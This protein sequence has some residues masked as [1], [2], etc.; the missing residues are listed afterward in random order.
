MC[1]SRDDKS[2]LFVKAAS[3][4]KR[5]RASHGLIQVFVLMPYYPVHA[6]WGVRCLNSQDIF[7]SICFKIVIMISISQTQCP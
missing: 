5:F 7:F 2:I 4:Y 6:W 1:T 3:L